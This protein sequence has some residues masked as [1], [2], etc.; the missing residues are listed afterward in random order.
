[1]HCD[2][3]RRDFYADLAEI[4]PTYAAYARAFRE[5]WVHVHSPYGEDFDLCNNCVTALMYREKLNPVTYS[6]R[7]EV[8]AHWDKMYPPK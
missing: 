8:L 4:Q 1:M 6:N 3:C 2:I 7:D 5:G